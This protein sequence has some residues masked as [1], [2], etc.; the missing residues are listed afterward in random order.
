MK[1]KP[2]R[3]SVRA[4]LLDE[5]GGDLIEGDVHQKAGRVYSDF[6]SSR[7]DIY[8]SYCIPL[9]GGSTARRTL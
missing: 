1:L 5:E 4:Q 7:V 8:L 9:C 6:A 3:S 2:T